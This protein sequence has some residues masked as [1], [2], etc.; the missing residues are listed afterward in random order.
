MKASALPGKQSSLLNT[1]LARILPFALL[2]L[3]ALFESTPVI[4]VLRSYAVITGELGGYGHETVLN[5]LVV[6]N[7]SPQTC[8][9]VSDGSTTEW[10]FLAGVGYQDFN[11]CGKTCFLHWN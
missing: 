3:P 9:N 5:I 6:S 10:I 11:N 1:L 8:R 7:F 4:S 2:I